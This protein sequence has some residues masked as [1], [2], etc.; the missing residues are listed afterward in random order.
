MKAERYITEFANDFVKG[1]SKPYRQ[2]ART[3]CDK[4]I[5]QRERGFITAFEAVREITNI[6]YNGELND[7]DV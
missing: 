3:E 2:A 6:Y 4:I 7:M 5:R 1:C